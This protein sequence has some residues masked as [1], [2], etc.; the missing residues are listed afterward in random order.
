MQLVQPK[1]RK[2]I[3]PVCAAA[4][5]VYA[6][7]IGAS[8]AGLAQTNTFDGFYKG[9]LECG[10]LTAGVG[11]SRVP[12]SIMVRD[13]RVMAGFNSDERPSTHTIAVG[14]I[15]PH[16]VFHLGTTVYTSNHSIHHDYSGTING[17]GGTLTGTQVVTREIGGDGGAR[18]CKGTFLRV[19]MPRQ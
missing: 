3:R 13:G 14:T 15:D 16:G 7:A 11:P 19:E 2:L 8:K 5:T 9:S 18:N 1:Q 10:E 6:V 12:L 17:S 4:L